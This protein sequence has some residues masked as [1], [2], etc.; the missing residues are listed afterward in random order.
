MTPGSAVAA[1]PAAAEG[2]A[3]AVA[4][5]ALF[6]EDQQD[7][8]TPAAAGAAATTPQGTGSSGGS[9]RDNKRKAA[10][11]NPLEVMSESR[12]RH[13]AFL[14]RL[15][16]GPTAAS[17]AAGLAGLQ[18]AGVTVP[19]GVNLSKVWQQ[20]QDVRKKQQDRLEENPDSDAGEVVQ[21]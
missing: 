2:S 11:V 6:A 13:K 1:A 14:D 12:Q 15:P 20:L 17:A 8:H 21:S 9:H 18:L 5:A 4:P 10:D 7:A 3:A 19:L 16:A